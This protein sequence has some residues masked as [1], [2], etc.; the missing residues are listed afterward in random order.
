MRAR[1]RVA[2]IP[3]TAA[4]MALLGI[5][6]SD[7]PS[8]LPRP[9]YFQGFISGITAVVFYAFGALLEDLADWAGL[10]VRVNDTARRVLKVVGIVLLVLA[11]LLYPAFNLVW[12]TLVT[13][14]F[15]EPQPGPL[16]P[17]LSLLVALVVM[18]VFIGVFRLISLLITWVTSRTERQV[19]RKALAKVIATVGTLL[20]LAAVMDQVVV[21][22]LLLVAKQQADAVN[23]EQPAGLRAPTEPTRSGGPGSLVP[24]GSIGADGSSFIASGPTAAEIATATGGRAIEPIRIFA[25]IADGRTQQQTLDLVLGEMERTRA[26]ERRAVLVLN[27]TSTGFVNEWAAESF[28]Y[29]LN[30][31]TAIV[32]MQY[33]TLPSALALITARDQPPQVGRLLFDAVAARRAALPAASKPRLYVGGESLGAYGGDGAFTSATDMLSKVDGALWTGTPSFTPIQEELTRDRTYGSTVAN[34][35]IADGR[36]IRF[37]GDATQLTKDQF[38]HVLGPWDAPRVVYLQHDTDPVVW[39]STDLLFR[40]PAW[41][42]EPGP[43]GT[44]MSLMSWT[45]VVTFW[46][47]TADMAMSNS[48][49]GGYGHRYQEAETVPAWAGILGMSPTADYSRIQ[50]AIKRATAADGG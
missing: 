15:N 48:F 14:Y 11:A 36:H 17:V 40:T 41:L 26:W 45:P 37:A 49:A 20:L 22:G 23:A 47:L 34:P 32:T 16:Y 21:R 30:G 7:T 43:P 3:R 6:A 18:G 12:H 50:A 13:L 35:V 19:A 46:Q 24:W 27:S 29:L 25:P 28:E 10:T 38:G 4:V 8:L 44:P 5:L 2:R 31:D 42:D 33:S 39:W 9:W 1:R